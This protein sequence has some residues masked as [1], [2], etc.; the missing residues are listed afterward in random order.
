MG[1]GVLT[2]IGC[3]AMGQPKGQWSGSPE[4]TGDFYWCGAKELAGEDTE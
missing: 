3:L 2:G 4:T 1:N